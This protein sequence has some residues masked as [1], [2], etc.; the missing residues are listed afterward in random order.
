MA[1]THTRLKN[2]WAE[3]RRRKVIR[4][5]VVYAVVAWLLVQVATQTFPVFEIPNHS[6][7]RIGP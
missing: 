6:G 2:W 7:F 1:D 3:A 4:V 5:A